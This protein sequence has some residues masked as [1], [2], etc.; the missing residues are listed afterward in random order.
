MEVHR[1][2]LLKSKYVS[3]IIDIGMM[4]QKDLSQVF[5]WGGCAIYPVSIRL[6]STNLITVNKLRLINFE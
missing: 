4:A 6:S 2:C 5:F 1:K 3:T